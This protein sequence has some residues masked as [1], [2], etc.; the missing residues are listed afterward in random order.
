LISLGE[1]IADNGGTKLSYLAYQK[2]KQRTLNSDNNLRLPGLE[3]NS[4][5]LFFI[6]FAHV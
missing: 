2:H 4:D 3:Y 5:Q 6:A 1:N